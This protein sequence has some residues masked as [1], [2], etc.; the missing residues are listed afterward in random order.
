MLPFGRMVGNQTDIW[1]IL[2][3]GNRMGCPARQDIEISRERRNI[4][5]ANFYM[6]DILHT[7]LGSYIICL[8]IFFKALWL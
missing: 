7:F 3:T 8:L 6:N 1:L 5:E 4:S 2:T